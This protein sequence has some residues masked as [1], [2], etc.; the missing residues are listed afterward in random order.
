M[1]SRWILNGM[2]GISGKSCGENKNI[3]SCSQIFFPEN[4]PVYE[5]I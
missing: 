2:G 1:I 3:I 5:A 4:R